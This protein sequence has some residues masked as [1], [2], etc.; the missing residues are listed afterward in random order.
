MKSNRSGD[1]AHDAVDH[2]SKQS[3]SGRGVVFAPPS[4]L[5]LDGFSV[6]LELFWQPSRGGLS[7]RQQARLA[8][9]PRG[10]FDLF[11]LGD[12]TRQV[13]F[14]SSQE[15]HQVG[16][17]AGAHLFDHA[18]PDDSWLGAFRLSPDGDN[19]WIVAKRQGAIYQD[20]VFDRKDK[21]V[22]EFRTLVEAP[23]WKRIIAPK[24]LHVEGAE[25]HTIEDIVD[26]VTGP[27][28]DPIDRSRRY[29][30]AIPVALLV[31]A[32]LYMAFDLYQAHS[33][34]DRLTGDSAVGPVNTT[35]LA[36]ETWRDELRIDQF[37]D[38]CTV[39]IDQLFFVVPGWEYS[40]MVCRM[41]RTNVSVL[42]RLDRLPNGVFGHLRTTALVKAGIEVEGDC[43]GNCAW[44]N[45]ANEVEAVPR[46]D[47][48]AWS[49]DKV[50]WVLRERFQSLHLDLQLHRR[51]PRSPSDQNG[52]T[53][54]SADSR[55][56]LSF[57]TQTGIMDYIRLLGDVP[58]LVPEAMTLSPKD[59]RWFVT[60]KVF[61][62]TGGNGSD[63][64]LDS[65]ESHEN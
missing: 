23:D 59:G 44:V 58:G 40:T 31:L 28:L 3:A 22:S 32:I 26:E 65:M 6:A 48:V 19:W 18:I 1:I 56:D 46:N 41:D 21:A 53:R 20:R 47:E 52:G 8:G 57:S 50:E 63:Y 10:S 7:I 33:E 37:A 25:E 2:D 54:S 15:G 39:Q 24:E 55:H 30:L 27:Q 38:E 9:G 4:A 13:G 12:Q 29:L 36:I 64:M 60:A 5:N 45:S 43:D 42:A 14:A 35:A 16:M 61:H 49:E 51:G 11:C 34:G 17:T 62:H